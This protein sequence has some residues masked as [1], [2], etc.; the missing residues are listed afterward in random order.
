MKQRL[1]KKIYRINE[2]KGWFLEEIN[3][4]DGALARLIKENKRERTQIKVVNEKG[5]FAINTIEI[6]WIIRD[7]YE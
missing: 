5:E 4:I 7:Y 3:K 2:T 6:K 1:K